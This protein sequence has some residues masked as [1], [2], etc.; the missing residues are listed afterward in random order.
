MLVPLGLKRQPLKS[1]SYNASHQPAKKSLL[2][3]SFDN[4]QF[5][6]DAHLHWWFG[7]LSDLQSRHHGLIDSRLG[8][9]QVFTVWMGDCGRTGKTS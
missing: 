4:D 3:D 5:W 8:R 7:P 6:Y 9:Y 1:T 2:Q